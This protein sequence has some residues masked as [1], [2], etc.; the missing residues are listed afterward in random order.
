MPSPM[1]VIASPL[2]YYLAVTGTAF[3]AIDAAPAAAWVK[4]GK[5][6]PLNY[7]DGGTSMKHSQSIETF[8][9]AGSTIPRKAFRTEEGLVMSVTIV[10]LSVASWSK[11]L[12]EAAVTTVPASSGVA[13]KK[14]FS[15]KRSVDVKNWALLA[16][17]QSTEDNTLNLQIEVPT[18]FQSADPSPVFTKGKPAALDL[19]FTALEVTPGQ[20][21][22]IVIQTAAALP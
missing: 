7:D 20:F 13:G 10:D 4:L 5:D 14:S 19:E 18:V 11:I 15:G 8:T 21:F 12:D 3:P 1:E 6:G 16:R 17:G 9:P 2:T 22:N